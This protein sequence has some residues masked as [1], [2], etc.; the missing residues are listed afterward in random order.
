MSERILIAQIGAAHGIKGEVRVKPFGDDPLALAEFGELQA[1]DGRRFRILAIRPA[2]GD[3]LIARLE[4]VD[5]RSSAEALNGLQLY[6]NR[7]SLPE[8]GDDEFYHAD[9]IGCDVLD[10]GGTP[11]GTVVAVPNYGAGDLLEIRLSDHRTALVPFTRDFVPKVDVA[12]RRVTIAPT[13]G[14]LPEDGAGT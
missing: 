12:A 2:K 10:D 6:V 1:A 3:M 8:P 14:L 9:L 11:L 5:D 4:G 13:E 7:A